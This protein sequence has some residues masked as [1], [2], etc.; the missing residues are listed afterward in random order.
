[1]KFEELYKIYTLLE[2]P[3][4]VVDPKTG[5]KV[6]YYNNAQSWSGYLVQTNLEDSVYTGYILH[7]DIAGVAGHE[8][9]NWIIKDGANPEDEYH[10]WFK[11]LKTNIP[12]DDMRSLWMSNPTIQFRLWIPQ[13][14]MSFWRPWGKYYIP[15]IENALK[16]MFQKPEEYTYEF[17]GATANT[18]NADYACYDYQGLLSGERLSA[19]DD[20]LAKQREDEWEEDKKL[21]AQIK[22]GMKPALNNKPR[23]IFNQG[24]GD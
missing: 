23:S 13:K 18:E 17:D 4:A 15:G 10:K 5:N 8:Y 1:M 11:R 14:V 3:N 20:R 7:T 12:I 21:L 19:F 6:Y 16:V 9:L 2:S 24:E 22:M